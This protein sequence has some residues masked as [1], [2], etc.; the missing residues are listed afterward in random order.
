MARSPG[1]ITDGPMSY[2]LLLRIEMTSAQPTSSALR[3]LLP[4]VRDI[5]FIFLFWSVLAGPLS[6]RPL[7]DADIGWHIRTGE[8]ILA[9]HSLPRIGKEFGKRD[10]TTVMHALRS[11]DEKAAL[12]DDMA[13]LVQS[14]LKRVTQQK[15]E[16][17]A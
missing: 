7:A 10:H 16:G 11:I 3:F 13:T 6:N 1:P 5:I 15:K 8:Q 17:C 12:D 9:T 4:S 14:L 2:K